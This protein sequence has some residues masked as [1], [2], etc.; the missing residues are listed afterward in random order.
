MPKGSTHA[1][2]STARLFKVWQQDYYPHTSGC[3]G[4]A[5]CTSQPLTR[6]SF[7]HARDHPACGL[8]ASVG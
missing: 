6:S 2:L 5:G 1:C 7:M 3:Q 8:V 4:P